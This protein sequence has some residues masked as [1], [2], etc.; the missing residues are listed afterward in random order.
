MGKT[1]SAAV[2]MTTKRSS[3]GPYMLCP[4]CLLDLDGKSGAQEQEEV[5]EEDGCSHLGQPV[6]VA[7]VCNAKHERI[8]QGVRAKAKAN[9]AGSV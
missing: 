9:L 7:N 2:H 1:A 4:V 5:D 3:A 8:R 6:F